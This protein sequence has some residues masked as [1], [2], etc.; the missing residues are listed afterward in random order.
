MATKKQI[1]A[2]VE[3]PEAPKLQAINQ[4]HLVG[5]LAADPQI[6]E[7]TTGKSVAT[8]R[9]AINDGK[10]T[11]YLNVVAWEDLASLAA[12]FH[13]GDAVDVTGRIRSRSWDSP[14]G[15]RYAVEV[16]ASTLAAA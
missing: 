10:A 8:L 9:L 4:V 15:K 1:P 3:Q 5:R 12:G 7:T 6:R 16:V 14:D 13:S 2:P 11:T